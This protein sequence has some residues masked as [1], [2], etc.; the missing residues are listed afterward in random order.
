MRKVCL[1]TVSVALFVVVVCGKVFTNAPAENIGDLIEVDIES[2]AKSELDESAAQWDDITDEAK[3]R[4]ERLVHKFTENPDDDWT[5]VHNAFQIET[6]SYRFGFVS[7]GLKMLY[8][9]R[10]NTTAAYHRYNAACSAIS[11]AKLSPRDPLQ[12]SFLA[13]RYARYCGTAS[14]RP[15]CEKLVDCADTLVN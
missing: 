1:F 10:Q 15:S 6:R 4:F 3:E 12:Y 2:I 9:H 13:D 7:Y 11:N 5:L 8:R 14:R